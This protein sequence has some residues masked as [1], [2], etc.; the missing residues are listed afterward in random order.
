MIRAPFS[1]VLLF[2][3]ASLSFGQ[4][5]SARAASLE[6]QNYRRAFAALDAGHADQA[7]SSASRDHDVVLNKVL[8][9]Y[10]LGAPGNDASYDDTVE[11]V[12]E[13]P[14]W[15]GLH[16]ILA[17][18]ERKIPADASA[19]SIVNWF[20]I[21][22]PVTLIGFYR[23]VDALNM[24]GQES[25]AENLV[26]ARWIDG[27][28][29]NDELAVFYTRY[30]TY[31]GRDENWAR[32]DKL[33]WSNNV[34]DAKRMRDMVDADLKSVADAR[35]ALAGQKFDAISLLG[36]V[37]H[38]L[39]SEPGLLY[40]RLRWL[41][42]NNHD[43]DA[44]NILDHAPTRLGKAEPWWEE[45]QIMV[46]RAMDKHDYQ[47]AYRLASAH[48]QTSP[49]T[50]TQAEFL[51]GWLAL[52]FL[53][54]PDDARDHFQSLI[55]AAT[56]PITRARGSYWLGRAYEASG[57][58]T[59]A[60]QSYEEAAQLDIAYYGQLASAR[61]HTNPVIISKPEPTVP[62]AARAKFNG[63]DMVRA[64]E[65]L[66]D[67]G[68][69]ERARLFFKALLNN[70]TVRTDYVQLIELAYRIQR[71]DMA[72]EAAKAADQKNMVVAAGG[73]PVLDRKVPKPPEPAFTHAVIRQE[74]MFNPDAASPVGAQGLM[75]LMPH[76]AKGMAKRLNI[77]FREKHL[78]DEDYNLR[79]GTAFIQDQID[80]FNG[81]YILALAGYNAGPG[82]AREWMEQIGDPRNPKVD[83]VD[84]IELIPVPETRNY[85]QRIMENL[86]I[87]RARL[88]GGQA[89]LLILKDLRR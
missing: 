23:Y 76:T 59:S 33:L 8:R 37:P 6:P 45:R 88:N 36:R 67:I 74:S 40:E 16:D 14:D 30:S 48:N 58:Q 13:N 83:P 31:L 65:R 51:A 32:L 42:R 18:A 26:R 53:N 70:A 44:V 84:W 89:P 66:H 71:P 7:Y 27:D 87:Y 81:S 34:S 39:Q 43:E 78:G 54:E 64:V 62:A 22:P 3:L 80:T 17:M 25:A 24:T 21:H 73:F 29:S 75:Q 60:Q 41:R 77:R 15:A 5:G 9:G 56:T 86:Q 61:I 68:Q 1:F 38:N 4:T 49:K 79:L 63:R 12:R 28:F 85:I 11:F 82:R 50:V 57:D 35:L 52:R 20:I 46:R 10:Y 47:Q 55:D 69:N 72:I 2:L 19:A